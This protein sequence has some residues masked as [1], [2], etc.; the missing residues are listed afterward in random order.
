MGLTRRALEAR[1]VP[2]SGLANPTSWFGDLMGG[3]PSLSGV[4]VT[5]ESAMSTPAVLN[6]VTLISK[7]IASLPLV[8]LRARA[9]GGTEVAH[10]HPLHRLLALQPN[11]LMTSFEFRELL[12]VHLETWGNFF[13]AIETS[14]GGRIT[15][16]WPLLPNQV[17]VYLAPDRRQIWYHW[18]PSQGEPTWFRADEL[19]H[20]RGMSSNG[21]IGQSPIGV[22][23]EALGLTMAAEEMAAAFF[24]NDATPGGVLE[25]PAKLGDKAYERLKSQWKERHGGPRNKGRFAV[26]EEGMQWKSIGMPL[27]DAQFIEHRKFQITEIARIFDLPPHKLK[28]LEKATFSNIEQQDTDFLVDSM[29]PR[30]VR[31]EQRL[32]TELL[33]SEEL[34]RGYVFKFRLQG[35]LRGD[36]AARG[37]WYALGRQWGWF[38]ADDVRDLEDMNPLPDGKG[39]DYMTPLNMIMAGTAPPPKDPPPPAPKAPPPES[40]GDAE[41][42]RQDLVARLVASSVPVLA[43]ALQRC[44]RKET[45]ATRRQLERNDDGATLATWH[46]TFWREH[47]ERV[48]ESLLPTC[49]MLAGTLGVTEPETLARALAAAA[50]ER[51]RSAARSDLTAAIGTGPDAIRAVLDAWDSTRSRDAAQ[52][53]RL[54]LVLTLTP[55][56][57]T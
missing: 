20:V 18:V 41:E 52:R 55:R 16:L 13:A 27:K 56:G 44:A 26:F 9:G 46:D 3:R 33:S 49:R 57:T 50:A 39:K 6:A 36:Q 2:M 54:E 24:G 43:D 38:S 40:D 31:I 51:E 5:P 53:E 34:D 8:L 19:L 48:S 37:A 47:V 15:A 23:R 22:A 25:H 30:F 10:E 35:R 12:A 28:D 45:L 14:R 4:T 17:T 11:P 42:D 21:Y 7:T 1:A 32:N 29:G